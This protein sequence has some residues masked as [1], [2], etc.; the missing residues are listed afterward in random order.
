MSVTTDV[1]NLGSVFVNREVELSTLLEWWD[2]PGSALGLVWGR[3]RVGKTALLEEFSRSRRT[4]FH[5]AA[6]R[7]QA[8]ELRLLSHDAAR[9]VDAGVRDLEARPFANWDDALD[10]L[11]QAATRERLLVVVDEFPELVRASP[12]LP[13]VL[14]A[15]WDRA[16]GRTKLRLL[17]CGSA[18]RTMHAIQEEPAP[19]YGRF[20][21][22]LL[23]HPFRPYEAAAMLKRLVPADRALV[24]GL[25]GGV[26]LYLEWWDE[27]ASVRDNLLRLACTPGGRLLSEGQLVMATEGDLGELG[28]LVL[29]AIAT[30]RTRHGEI[31]QA[32][33]AEPRRVLDRL[34][35]LR[36]VER[37]VPVTENPARTRRR[38][39][40]IA[41][42]F[43][44]FW[45][46]LLDRHRSAIE[47]GL[48]RQVLPVLMKELD[49]HMG[50]RWEGA[51]RE[52]LV[53]MAT[54][55]ELGED[56]VDI[57]RWWRDSPPVEIDAVALAGRRRA[58]VLVGEAKWAKR[59]D[60]ERVR[61]ELERTAE[62]L[63]RVR[64]DLRYAVCGRERVD[65]AD[66]VLTVTAGDIF[67][68]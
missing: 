54:A 39:Y 68:A 17:L 65:R 8:D 28:E 43:L 3:R 51:F 10:T 45:L 16:R 19:L 2:R 31:E 12:D 41:D 61:R 60:A 7:P 24:W 55:G 58:A 34:I 23:L 29:R 42:N 63:P 46:G 37:L 66:D 56:V 33:R 49:D 52:H 18:V 62:A 30:G 15:F 20:D 1:G 26:P 44:A 50:G 57:G 35:E 38:I 32:V 67:G 5:T 27:A 4:V 53:R 9:A 11:A 59:V 22:S 40:R 14:R 64:G 47:R 36:L 13:G 21:L 25:V 48:G 6:G